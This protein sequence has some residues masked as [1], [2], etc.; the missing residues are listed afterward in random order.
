[1][2][3]DALGVPSGE[4]V[5]RAPFHVALR[6]THWVFPVNTCTSDPAVA[7]VFAATAAPLPTSA[8]DMDH[9][10]HAVSSALPTP[11]L[12]EHTPQTNSLA[13]PAPSTVIL[14]KDTS[15]AISPALPVHIDSA[16]RQM[17]SGPQAP[18]AV[19]HS[20][21]RVAG[22]NRA[23]V[24][25]VP[26]APLLLSSRYQTALPSLLLSG[27]IS[28]RTRRRRA[29]ATGKP[30]ASVDYVF[31]RS[32][33]TPRPVPTVQNPRPP[34][35]APPSEVAPE[36]SVDPV[37]AVPIQDATDAAPLAPPLLGALP[38]MHLGLSAPLPLYPRCYHRQKS[39]SSNLSGDSRTPIGHVNNA[40]NRSVTPPSGISFV[41]VP[42]SSPTISSST[43]LL[44]NAPRCRKCVL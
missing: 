4:F 41:E 6:D 9:G 18:S 43:W 21:S 7:S 5:A 33:P 16:A 38:Q 28:S 24:P 23:Q 30:Q 20:A 11:L 27:L 44:T 34:R 13:A 19:L 2:R 42:R 29:A 12:D 26:A 15:G 3:V 35:S 36:P 22:N 1:M 8:D 14:D 25:I 40:P 10:Q 17:D 31:N 32:D 37:P 39:S